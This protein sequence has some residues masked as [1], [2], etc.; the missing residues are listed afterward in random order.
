MYMCRS[1]HWACDV[2]QIFT[3]WR[4]GEIGI[5]QLRYRGGAGRGG[6]RGARGR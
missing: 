5:A 2:V 3:C 4:E 1:L 6:R